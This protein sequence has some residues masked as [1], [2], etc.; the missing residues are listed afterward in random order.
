MK[1]NSMFKPK[2]PGNGDAVQKGF[3]RAAKA[4]VSIK[5]P[6]KNDYNSKDKRSI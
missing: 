3:E 6:I 4:K 1:A 5:G 2:K